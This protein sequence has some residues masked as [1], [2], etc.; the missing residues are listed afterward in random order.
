MLDVIA[1]THELS[2]NKAV[3]RKP[4]LKKANGEANRLR[5]HA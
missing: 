4:G 2:C 5:L 3:A 1:L